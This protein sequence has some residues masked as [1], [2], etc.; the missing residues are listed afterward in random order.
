MAFNFLAQIAVS[1]IVKELSNK[2]KVIELGN[3]RFRYDSN[4]LDRCEKLSNKK[5]RRPVEYVWEFYEDIGFIDYKA[6]DVNDKLKAIP[7][8]LNFILKD[9]FN[10]IEQFDLVTNNGTGEHIFNQASVFENMHNLCKEGGIMLNILPFAPWFNHC[11]Y[12]YHPIF[13][14]DLALSNQ[15]KFLNFW[16]GENKGTYFDLFDLTKFKDPFFE[17]K[18]PRKPI[19]QLEFA[20]DYF[21][22]RSGRAQNVSIV[23]IYQKQNSQN[24]AMPFQGNYVNDITDEKL[25]IYS[26]SNINSE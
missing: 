17:Q 9:K 1:Q 11:F 25:K 18:Q 26:S 3:Q 20:F 7:M 6:I 19:S 22:N 24:F 13:F 5:I 23:A 21:N 16:I 2:P 4:I 14:R 8:D 12:S 10:Y 15:Y